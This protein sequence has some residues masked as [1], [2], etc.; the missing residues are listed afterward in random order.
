MTRCGG[1]ASVFQ[2]CI[3]GLLVASCGGGGGGGGGG[4]GGGSSTSSSS[5][6]SSS[7]SSSSSSG[8]TGGISTPGAIPYTLTY[9]DTAAHAPP[10]ATTAAQFDY[11]A[12][13]PNDPNFP[14]VRRYYVDPVFGAPIRRLTSRMGQ[15]NNDDIYAHHWA[16]ADGTLA[17]TGQ[18]NIVR[19]ADGVTVYSNQPQGSMSFE[20]YWDATDPD[21]YYYYNGTNLMVRSLSAQTSSVK[22]NFGPGNT[23]QSLGG[24]LNFQT[25]DGR[26]FIVQYGGTAK[27]WDSQTDT[28]YSGSATQASP[29]GWIS[30]TPSG[31]HIVTAAGPNWEHYSYAIDHTAKSI[32][33]TPVMFWSACG[34]HG[35]L[36]SA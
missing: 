19:L 1:F 33:A 3:V 20:T 11:N 32:A 2:V 22:K 18:L 28:I 35:V 16:N 34:D 5:G 31:N 25:R 7:G 29:D 10:S 26:Y 4:S 21:K 27:V 30:I 13:T 15:T 8:S 17:F 36:L 14:A 23:L 6:S 12:F 24:S 9:Q